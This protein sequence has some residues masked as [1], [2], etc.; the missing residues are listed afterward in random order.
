MDKPLSQELPAA[1]VARLQ[2]EIKQMF[3]EMEQ[4]DIRI[5]RHHERTERLRS[6]TRAILAS[7]KAK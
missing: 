2:A 5:R 6:E 3:A 7:L 1:E 4:A